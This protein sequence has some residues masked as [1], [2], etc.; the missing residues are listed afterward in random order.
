MPRTEVID[1]LSNESSP[2]Q[3]NLINTTLDTTLALTIPSPITSQAILTQGINVSPLAH[4]S[5]VFLTST[6]SPLEPHLYLTSLED[7]PPRSS[8]PPPPSSSLGFSQTLPQQTPMDFK[9]SF[10]PINLSRSRISAQ[11]E[12][13]LSRDQVVQELS[14]HQDF[15]HHLEAIIQN[16]QNSLLPPF[17]TTSPQMPPIPPPFHFTTTF[18][19]STSPF[20]TSLPPSST[21][22]PLDQSLWMKG[23]SIP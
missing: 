17:T 12:P 14:Q 20:R 5:L 4:R 8:N 6:S 22:V 13:F 2:I 18:T 15:D 7:L 9:P 10:S 3:N 16:A 11:P 21:F 1:I 23:P 19:T